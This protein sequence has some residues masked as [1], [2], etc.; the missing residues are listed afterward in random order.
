MKKPFSKFAI[1]LLLLALAYPLLALPDYITSLQDKSCP[2]HAA[3]MNLAATFSYFCYQVRA[4]I[5]T[6]GMLSGL[7]FLIE[8]VDRIRWDAAHRDK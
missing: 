4:Q 1:V 6:V 8:L 3:C 7:A 2:A 5:L